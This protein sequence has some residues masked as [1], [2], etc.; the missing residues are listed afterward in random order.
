MN[1]INKISINQILCLAEIKKLNEKALSIE[2]MSGKNIRYFLNAALS[3][4]D[5][6]YLEIGCWKGSTLYSALLNN[7]PNYALAIDNFSEFGGP[8]EQFYENMKDLNKKFDFIDQDCFSIDKSKINHKFNIYFYDGDHSEESHEKAL[9]YFYDILEDNFIYICDDW[10][11]EQVRNGT[12][13]GIE[14]LNLNIKDEK[15]FF[16]DYQDPLSWWNGIYIAKLSK[17]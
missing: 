4:D 12:K 14:K 11:W 9:S 17:D 6:K 5:V 7:N 3:F 10:N 8:R 2:G 16:T 1:L 13:K 15:S